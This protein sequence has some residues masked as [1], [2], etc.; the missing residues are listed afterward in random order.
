MLMADYKVL[1]TTSGLG[2][3]LGNLTQFTNKGLVRVG[4]KAVI[5]HIIES[6][7]ANTEFVITLGHFGNHVKQYLKIAYPKYKFKFVT[8]KNYFG[9]GS[10]LL[11]SISIA[12]KYLQCKFIFH[13]CDTLI[14]KNLINQINFN[15]N[16]IAGYKSKSSQAYRTINTLN[17]KVLK[18]NEKGEENYDYIYIGIAGIKNYN[19]FWKSLQKNLKTKESTDLSDYLVIKDMLN[20]DKFMF[21]ESDL[22]YDTGNVDS[23]QNARLQYK[24]LLHVLNKDDENIF[25]V[26]N[27]VIKFFSD[28]NKCSNRI[29]RAKILNKLVPKILDSSLNFYSYNFV[30]GKIFS[31]IIDNKKFVNLLRW[32]N[33]NLWIPKKIN[34]EEFKKNAIA[35]YKDKTNK[36]INIFL[37]NNNLKDEVNIINKIQVPKLKTLIKKINF[38]KIIGNNA[39]GF[40]GDFISDNILINDKNK[41]VLIDWR[42][43]FNN[44]LSYGD[45]NYDL[46]KLNHNLLFNHSLILKN[47]FTIEIGEEIFLELLIK[48]SSLDYQKILKQFCKV[49]KIDFKSIE[50]LT[51]LIWISMAPLHEHPLDF[52][53]YFFGK[54][55][56]MNSL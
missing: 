26:K 53:L 28:E 19:E 42:E 49:H 40:H 32:A 31:E 3:R 45:R 51:S 14:D 50:I 33:T 17:N 52:F 47:N 12:K 43:E 8:V 55:N 35:F 39:S 13:A 24:T 36:R 41:F 4:D 15:N 21:V 48:K 37:N 25:I 11:H 29:E 22:W 54:Y 18:L 30:K 16:W 23:L 46:A 7:S 56:L 10:S 9:K 34:Y 1:I 27:K 44:K 6:Y 5:S 2:S 38:E 20:K